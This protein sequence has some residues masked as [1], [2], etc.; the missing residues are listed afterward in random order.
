MDAGRRHG[1]SQ[2]TSRL[3]RAY[4]NKT[5]Q[6]FKINTVRAFACEKVS[7]IICCGLWRYFII[8][9]LMPDK[10]RDASVTPDNRFNA[11]VGSGEVHDDKDDLDEMLDV[12]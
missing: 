4:I 8:P 7:V 9:F 5:D 1:V 12:S 2:N 10:A 6:N 3:R 11:L